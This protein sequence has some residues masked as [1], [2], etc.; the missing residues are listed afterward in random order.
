MTTNAIASTFS[1]IVNREKHVEGQWNNEGL[2][3]WLL[4]AF[5]KIY[6]PALWTKNLEIHKQLR[7]SR[8][9]VSY[10]WNK[11]SPSFWDIAYF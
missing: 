10:A 3:N 1:R 8:W 7:F 9:G 6:K 2:I 11:C 4:V 5:R